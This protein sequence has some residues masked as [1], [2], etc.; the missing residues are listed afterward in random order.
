[1][2]KFQ[3]WIFKENEIRLKNENELEDLYAIIKAE[4]DFIIQTDEGCQIVSGSPLNVQFRNGDVKLTSQ[5]GD[6]IE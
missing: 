6:G 4:E 1:M 2:R 5:N 3:A